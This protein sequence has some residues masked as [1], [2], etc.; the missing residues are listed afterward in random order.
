VRTG[1]AIQCNTSIISQVCPR[2][3]AVTAFR[4]KKSRT[5]HTFCIL[6]SY[7]LFKNLSR[8]FCYLTYYTQF[9]EQ[10]FDD[11]M[12]LC[13]IW[14]ASISYSAENLEHDP[15]P[16]VAGRVTMPWADLPGRRQPRCAMAQQGVLW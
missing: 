14:M 3:Q 11:N 9:F 12:E 16:L 1:A 6:T 7:T 5:A 13:A 8:G 15:Q 2:S 10:I 4:R